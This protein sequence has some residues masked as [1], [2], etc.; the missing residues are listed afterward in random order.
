LIIAKG[1]GYY[2]A[3]LQNELIKG[4]QIEAGQIKSLLK[5]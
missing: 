5:G 1:S 3:I 2:I 4:L